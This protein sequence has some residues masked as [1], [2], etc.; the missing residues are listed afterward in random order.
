LIV[1]LVGRLS[2]FDNAAEA[3]A[4]A[5]LNRSV[6]L[7]SERMG[8]GLLAGRLMGKRSGF[9]RYFCGDAGLA[10]AG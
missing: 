5:R 9:S 6:W 1:M 8:I 7:V 10:A 2:H 4:A 3:S